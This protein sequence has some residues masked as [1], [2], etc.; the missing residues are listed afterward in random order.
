L[1][2]IALA[3]RAA[4]SEAK[5]IAN[6]MLGLWAT[7]DEEPC[8]VE[9]RG[10]P[11][12]EGFECSRSPSACVGSTA[13]G[14]ASHRDPG[15]IA[16]DRAGFSLDQSAQLGPLLG[17]SKHDESEACVVRSVPWHVA[18]S[19]Q[20]QRWQVLGRSVRIKTVDQCRPH[21]ASCMSGSDADLLDVGAPID[22]GAEEVT[23]LVTGCVDRNPRASSPNK[24]LQLGDRKRLVSG[25]L[26][27]PDR[28][29][30]TARIAFDLAQSLEFITARPPDLI[31][32]P[33]TYS[34]QHG[35]SA[36]SD[37][38]HRSKTVR[39]R[40]A[41]SSVWARGRGRG[42]AGGPR[43]FGGPPGSILPLPGAA[44]RGSEAAVVRRGVAGGCGGGGAAG[45]WVEGG[46][47]LARA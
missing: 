3:R 33:S 43:W 20:R 29:K 36:A 44:L 23:D 35:R 24:R 37:P 39:A 17:R 25:D 7:R 14:G 11:H 47:L 42:W 22:N 1:V 18:E 32:H 28:S 30:C 2:A 46:V 13:A 16:R 4:V 21:A 8:G 31:H 40:P 41:G 38:Q 27:H 45:L 6:A 34:S 12:R 19:G 5:A 26:G 9:M 10:Q 15:R